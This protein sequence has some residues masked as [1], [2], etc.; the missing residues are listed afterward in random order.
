MEQSKRKVEQKAESF[1]LGT[2]RT[3]LKLLL[4]M[5]TAALLVALINRVLH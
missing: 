2:W 1:S 3:F 5:G 4:I